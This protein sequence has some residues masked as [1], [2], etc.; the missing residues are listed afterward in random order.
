MNVQVVHQDPGLVCCD[1]KHQREGC[2]LKILEKPKKKK[3]RLLSLL[4]A[5]PHLF[6][7]KS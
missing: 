7:A 2:H 4:P 6:I 1:F 3:K 5:F